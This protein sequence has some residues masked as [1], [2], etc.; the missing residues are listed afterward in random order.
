[1]G[2]RSPAGV[3]AWLAVAGILILFALALTWLAVIPGPGT[4]L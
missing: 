4:G 1:M 3:L 2:I